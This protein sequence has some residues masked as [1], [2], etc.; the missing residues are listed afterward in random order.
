MTPQPIHREPSLPEAI[1]YAAEHADSE[2]R[3]YM[4][5]VQHTKGGDFLYGAHPLNVVTSDDMAKWSIRF[6]IEAKS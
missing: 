5:L 3:K 2:E 6:V 4:V 1:L